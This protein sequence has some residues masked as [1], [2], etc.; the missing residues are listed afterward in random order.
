MAICLSKT[1][2]RFLVEPQP[3]YRDMQPDR[4]PVTIAPQDDELLSSWLHRLALANGLA[5]R[6][7]SDVLGC[8]AG[9]WSAR[10]DLKLPDGI[11]DVLHQ[12]TDVARERILRMTLRV[13]P[14]ARLLLPLSPRR[15]PQG[16]DL[17]AILSTVPC[18]R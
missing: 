10:L 8:G 3:R 12:Q 7:L 6:H 1:A 18:G 9:M 14:G 5:P 2:A 13:G 11:L 4:W 16:R 15:R 17:A